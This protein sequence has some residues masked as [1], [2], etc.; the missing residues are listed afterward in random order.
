MKTTDFEQY[1]GLIFD[2]DGTI[3][4]S[5]PAHLQTWLRT[6]AHFDFP[7][8]KEWLH[9]M[10]GMPSHKITQEINQRYQLNLDPADVQTFKTREFLSMDLENI[11]T[12]I[13]CTYALVKHFS[14]QKPMA[15]G[16]GS[17]TSTATRLLTQLGI[18]ELFETIVTANDVVNHK[19]NPDT[20]LLAAKRINIEPSACVVFEDTELGLQA[21]HAAGMDC[22]LVKDNQLSFHPVK[23][24]A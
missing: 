16:T 1:Q 5:M 24:T 3:I 8:D 22:V 19:P 18:I 2:M 13:P 14:G 17:S 6:S 7:Y 10:G 23:Q 12:L 21:A 20:F 4:D 9:S 15:V 11:V